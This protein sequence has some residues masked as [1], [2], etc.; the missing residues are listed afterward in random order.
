MARATATAP[1][2]PWVEEEKAQEYADQFSMYPGGK[3]SAGGGRASLF[4]TNILRGSSKAY[5]GP[6]AGKEFRRD[7][8]QLGTRP[9]RLLGEATGNVAYRQGISLTAS[10]PQKTSATDATL[11]EQLAVAGR[12]GFTSPYTGRFR[13][14]FISSGWMYQLTQSRGP[15]KAPYGIAQSSVDS[16]KERYSTEE[17][18]FAQPGVYDTRE[19][20]DPKTQRFGRKWSGGKELKISRRWKHY[21]LNAATMY[22]GENPDVG[23]ARRV[24]R[25]I[26]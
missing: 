15:N 21:T 23:T 14:Q 22:Q 18:R 1:S 8:A 2:N 13:N 7:T 5:L 20:W 6:G 24:K 11:Y 17:T 4:K 26:L 12:L 25:T 10:G 9:D 16:T 19:K 3:G